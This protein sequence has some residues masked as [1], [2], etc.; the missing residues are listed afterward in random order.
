MSVVEDFLKPHGLKYED[1]TPDEQVTLGKWIDASDEGKLTPDK[2]RDYLRG[3]II[4]VEREL[5]AT[6]EFEYVLI[7]KRRS[8]KQVMLKA[9]L[10]NYMT[11]EQIFLSPNQA[12]KEL[13]D[14][15]ARIANSRPKARN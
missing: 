3:L 13:A 15:L 11:I 5:V 12:K 7:F 9:R 8:W 2:I 4:A 1:L 10:Q 14:G 6:D